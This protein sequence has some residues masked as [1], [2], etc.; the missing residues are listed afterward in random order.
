MIKPWFRPWFYSLKQYKKHPVEY[1]LYTI[2]NLLSN[3]EEICNF[4][5]NFLT[6]GL[7]GWCNRDIWNFDTYLLDIII[8]GLKELK[9]IKHGYPC[10]CNVMS[11]DFDPEKCTC[12]DRWD[13]VLYRIVE[14][15]EAGKNLYDE[16]PENPED[17]KK[18]DKAMQLFYDY[19][20]NLWD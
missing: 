3:L 12:S 18:F 5:Q 19:F 13:E 6:R 14:G 8:G 16:Y 10:K 2:Y 11:E 7:Y 20:F 4:I 1:V 15:F 9:K 17:R